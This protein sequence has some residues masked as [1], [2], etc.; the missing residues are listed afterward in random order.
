MRIRGDLV[1]VQAKPFTEE[2]IE[3]ICKI[4]FE[5]DE[6]IN[7]YNDIKE[8]DGSF[9]IPDLCRLRFNFYRYN[10]NQGIILRIVKNHIPTID[11]LGLPPVIKSIAET[12]RGL[13]LVTG[14]TGSGKS[15]TLAAMI[16]H[17]N[18]N[19]KAHIITIEDPIEY[20]H[21]QINSRISQREVGRDTKN[22]SHALRAA[23]RQDPDIILIG[24]MRDTE[25]IDI[26]LKAAETGHAVFSTVHTTNAIS[27]IGRIVSMFPPEEQESIRKRMAISLSSTISQRMLK[28]AEEDKI[29]VA[30]EIMLTNP[31]VKEC[32]LGD[33]PL[34]NLPGVI[35]KTKEPDGTGGQTFDQHIIELYDNNLITKETA[36]N[37]VTSQTDF[38][39]RLM[40]DD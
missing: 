16:N 18:Q 36:L 38:M 40:Q 29:I 34:G 20:L 17:I 6:L 28:S 30:Q 21:P 4:L 26:S 33:E 23:L 32:I 22:F 12:K 15:T 11:E 7:K 39:Q 5:E 8:Q 37:A 13:I 35:A 19:R 9:T 27:T 14:A 10:L 3:D 24:E 1:S 2:N 31:G 25:T